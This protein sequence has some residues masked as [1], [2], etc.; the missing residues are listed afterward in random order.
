MSVEEIR[1][2]SIVY[3]TILIIIIVLLI[4]YKEYSKIHKRRKRIK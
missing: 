4:F 3:T 1:E 2:K